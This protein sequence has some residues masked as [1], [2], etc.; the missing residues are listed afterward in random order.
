VTAQFTAQ[1]EQVRAAI[2]A[3]A[4]QLRQNLEDQGVKIEAIEVS[5]ESHQLEKNLDENNQNEQNKE[6]QAE[7]VK[8]SRRGSINLNGFEDD[9]ELLEEMQGADDATRIAMEMM[10]ANGNS[11]D[12][13]A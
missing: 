5:V 2:E 7:N 1:S 12:L 3:Q 8:S 11:M 4:T 6:E 9:G 13:L 10:S